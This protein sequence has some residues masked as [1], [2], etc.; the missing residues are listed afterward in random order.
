MYW[1]QDQATLNKGINSN[2]S[3]A[4]VW[5]IGGFNVT[6]IQVKYIS[7]AKGAYSCLLYWIWYD[8]PSE[9]QNIS[10]VVVFLLFSSKPPPIHQYFVYCSNVLFISLLPQH[11]YAASQGSMILLSEK[12]LTGE[13]SETSFWYKGFFR[14]LRLSLSFSLPPILGLHFSR[15]HSFC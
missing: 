14:A 6:W 2:A 12:M 10:I 11:S 5:I 4:W 15:Q 8:L 3:A 13:K 9:S 1:I 7:S